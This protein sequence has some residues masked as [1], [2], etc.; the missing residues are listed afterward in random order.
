MSNI[1][2]V[3]LG[4]KP[5]RG[6]EKS[7]YLLG[8][9]PRNPEVKSWRP[10]AIQL[11]EAAGYNGVV[12][13][14]EVHP[15]GDEHVDFQE[16][17]V[18]LIEWQERC[19]NL[20]DVIIAWVPRNMETMPGLTTNEEW[21][22]WKDSGKI[23]FGA[24]ED[25]YSTRYLKH[26]AKKLNVPE[27]TTLEQTVAN[28]L[29]LLG[30]GAWRTDGEREIPL[31]VWRTD[32]FQEWYQAQRDAGNVLE[33]ARVVWTFR[34]GKDRRLVFFWAL[35]AEV[36]IT[37]EGRSKTNEVVLSRPDIATIVL[38][39]RAERLNDS[40]VVLIRE[41]RTP[42][43]NPS[44]YVWEVPGGS[45]FKPVPN[46]RVLASEECQEETGLKLPAD[47]FV[48]YGSRQLVATMSAHRAHLFAAELNEEEMEILR[49]KQGIPQGVLEDTERTYVEIPTLR[50][51]REQEL[52]DWPTL[53]MIL[54][55]LVE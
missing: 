29:E 15:D 7:I 40:R 27:A 23:V 33:H 10:Q 44:G 41:F 18:E 42:V 32:R 53:G 46:P 50:E 49:Q 3:Y 55:V 8:P 51:I 13:I 25:A 4:E 39:Q 37:A 48:M 9:T 52:V 35:H 28:A 14:P 20:A 22:K 2:V 12:F 45:S 38:Y 16:K 24:P 30:E 19:L 6:Y 1:T 54:H 26:Y 5:P 11:L 47:R 21:G 36:Y 43:S 31:F 34:V 17:Y